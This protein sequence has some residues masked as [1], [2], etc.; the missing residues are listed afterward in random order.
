MLVA[1][2]LLRELVQLASNQM[3][4]FGEKNGLLGTKEEDRLLELLAACLAK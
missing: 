1:I 3:H 2:L 4:P